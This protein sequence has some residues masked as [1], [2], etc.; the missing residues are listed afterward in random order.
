WGIEARKGKGHEQRELRVQGWRWKPRKTKGEEDPGWQQAGWV[1][2]AGDGWSQG[3]GRIPREGVRG[4]TGN[5][6]C[7]AK[8]RWVDSRKDGGLGGDEKRQ[9]WFHGNRGGRKG[10]KWGGMEQ[11]EGVRC[12]HL[13]KRWLGTKRGVSGEHAGKAA[14]REREVRGSRGL[15]GGEDRCLAD[16]RNQAKDGYTLISRGQVEG[17]CSQQ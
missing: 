5:K 12:G 13:G 3:E 1:E 7:Y 4:G 17:T 10:E 11:V 9:Q 8:E 16:K 14:E 2:E 15:G 6:G